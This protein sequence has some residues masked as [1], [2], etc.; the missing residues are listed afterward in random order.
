[1]IA[2]PSFHKRWIAILLSL[3]VSESDAR[4]WLQVVDPTIFVKA[5]YDAYQGLQ[6]V[7]RNPFTY[8]EAFPTRA[9]VRDGFQEIFQETDTFEDGTTVNIT[10][11]ESIPP[12]AAPIAMTNTPAPTARYENVAENGGCSTG[13][14]LYM[15]RMQDMWGDGW[16]ETTLKIV[17]LPSLRGGE[18]PVIVQR[19]NHTD[20]L[21]QEVNIDPTDSTYSD[22]ASTKILF[23]GAL[24]NG[25]E[26]DSYVCLKPQRC[27]EVFVT[28][29]V[30]NTE[31]KWT[32]QAAPVSNLTKQEREQ[33][34]VDPIVKGWS[35]AH[36][37]FSI[38]EEASAD[39]VQDCPLSCDLDSLVTSGSPESSPT[40]A[41]YVD[42]VKDFQSPSV[43][44]PT[45]TAPGA[46]IS[47]YPSLVPS[48][49]PTEEDTLSQLP[50]VPSSIGPS[51]ETKESSYAPSAVPTEE[52]T[53]SQLPTV[54]SSIGPSVQTKEYSY[55]PSDAP[56]LVPSDVPSNLVPSNVPS[57]LV[58]SNVPSNLPTV[59]ASKIK[60]ELT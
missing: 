1:M 37:M 52:D 53:L 27:Y 31:V 6:S 57:N 32:I 34:Q 11:N 43:A 24:E 30:W 44:A 35:P 17:Q 49:V 15:I 46:S 16:D 38:P 50:T 20:T 59:A 55:A 19:G 26:E 28:G 8:T 45:P 18:F 21:S 4:T 39:V 58:P 51:V 25:F 9:P 40:K 33:E 42:K 23:E 56:S 10:K 22:A 36:C 54:L 41:P 60:L 3:V 14:Y 5:S 7:E 48:S 29:G 13:Q 12:S 47:D 2:N